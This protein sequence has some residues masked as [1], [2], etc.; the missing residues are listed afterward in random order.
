MANPASKGKLS[1]QENCV[2]I[3]IWGRRNAHGVS[4]PEWTLWV[5]A[6]RGKDHALISLPGS[7]TRAMPSSTPMALMIRAKYGGMRNLRQSSA[8]QC[9]QTQVCTTKPQCDERL[10]SA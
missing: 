2:Y 10:P 8:S 9:Y 3:H 6:I 5:L 7:P 4:M 1:H